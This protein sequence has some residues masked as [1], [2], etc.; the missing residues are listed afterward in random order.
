MTKKRSM[1]DLREMALR[2]KPF[3]GQKAGTTDDKK[4]VYGGRHY[5]RQEAVD[6][7]KYFRR[8]RDPILKDEANNKLQRYID[9]HDA[10]VAEKKKKKTKS[11]KNIKM[12]GSSKEDGVIQIQ[13]KLL[14]NQRN[15]K[16]NMGGVMRNRGGTFKGVF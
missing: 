4:I 12:P 3:L 2:S 16:M 1:Y 7:Q 14:F 9:R 8:T 15:K 6:M 13:E 11:L 5:T 10:M